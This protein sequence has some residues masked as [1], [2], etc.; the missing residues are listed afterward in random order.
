MTTIKCGRTKYKTKLTESSVSGITPK[1][2]GNS[3]G[4]YSQITTPQHARKP[5]KP[6]QPP[7]PISPHLNVRVFSQIEESLIMLSYLVPHRTALALTMN[8]VRELIFWC[9]NVSH[10]PESQLRTEYKYRLVSDKTQW[11]LPEITKKNTL[12]F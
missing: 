11:R 1:R 9:I 12:F 5:H 2:S 6:A 7:S 4:N 8:L 10:R 3:V